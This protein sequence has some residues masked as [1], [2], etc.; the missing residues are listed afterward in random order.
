MESP[1][2]IFEATDINVRK[3]RKTTLYSAGYDIFFKRLCLFKSEMQNTNFILRGFVLRKGKSI[4]LPLGFKV[5]FPAN[6][7]GRLEMRSSAAKQLPF[8]MVRGG[9]IGN[10]TN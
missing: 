7:M 6:T 3:P 2:I 8:I 10:I 1:N 4:I 9:I 5:R